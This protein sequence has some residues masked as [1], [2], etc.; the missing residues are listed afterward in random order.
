MVPTTTAWAPAS[1]AARA[2]SGV[3]KRPSAM[4]GTRQWR[5]QR[6]APAPGRVRPAWARYRRYSPKAWSTHRRRRPF[7]RRCLLRA[8]RNR[9]RPECRVRPMIRAINSATASP[10]RGRGRAVDGD[11][12][13]AGFR[14]H[15]GRREIGGDVDGEGVG[16]HLVDADDRQAS[17]L[18]GAHIVGAIG[19][20]GRGAARG[21]GQ[22]HGAHELRAMQGIVG[23]RL[24]GDDQACPWWIRSFI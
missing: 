20:D 5:G 12:V 16:K 10:S 2:S 7:R 3:L 22:R 21:R 8:W 19:A 23:P 4:I 24:A 11:D 18:D 17:R 1:S 13:G 6:R 15:L 14:Q 9:Q